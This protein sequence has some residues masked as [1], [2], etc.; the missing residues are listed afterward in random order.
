MWSHHSGSKLLARS[1]RDTTELEDEPTTEGPGPRA[2]DAMAEAV[3][4]AR[5]VTG[6]LPAP[7]LVRVL[8]PTPRPPGSS[9]AAASRPARASTPAAMPPREQPEPRARV[10]HDLGPAASRPPRASTPSPSPAPEATLLPKRGALSLAREPED[11]SDSAPRAPR[12]RGLGRRR[13]WRARAIGAAMCALVIAVIA[14]LVAETSSPSRIATASSSTVATRR[15]ASRAANQAFGDRAHRHDRTAAPT[16]PRGSGSAGSTGSSQG[17][18]SSAGSATSSGAA[19]GGQVAPGSAEAKAPPSSGNAVS[20]PQLTGISPMSG[21]PGEDVVVTGTNL[22][23]ADGEILA[24]FAGAPAPTTCPG[25]HSCTLVVPADPTSSAT[26]G[27]TIT[28]QSGTSNALTFTYRS[29]P[30]SARVV[31]DRAG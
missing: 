21:V 17:S 15:A 5:A 11:L 28:T 13:R 23:S 2:L 6:D 30:S 1:R 7:T 18:S 26:V 25:Q 12:A 8:P 3:K 16:A 29:V 24:H 19:P 31:E 10:G 9:Y 14:L 22:F 20:L 4:R 27:V